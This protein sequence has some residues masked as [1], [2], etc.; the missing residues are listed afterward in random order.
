M[1]FFRRKYVNMPARPATIS[2]RMVILVITCLPALLAGLGMIALWF[3][4]SSKSKTEYYRL[5]AQNVS[6]ILAQDAELLNDEVNKMVGHLAD[7]FSKTYEESVLT[8]IG[9]DTIPSVLF[10]QLFTVTMSNDSFRNVGLLLDNALI[11]TYYDRQSGAPGIYY[12]RTQEDKSVLAVRYLRSKNSSWK[13]HSIVN[14]KKLTSHENTLYQAALKNPGKIVVSQPFRESGFPWF[15][16]F[17]ASSF[18]TSE[19][20]DGVVFG[21]ISLHDFFSMYLSSA[22]AGVDGSFLILNRQGQ[23]L[24]FRGMPDL[25]N[26][27]TIAVPPSCLDI[28]PQEATRE[29]QVLQQAVREGKLK[30]FLDP[31]RM[32]ASND[33]TAEKKETKF[34]FSLFSIESDSLNDDAAEKSK[35]NS[36]IIQHVMNRKPESPAASTEPKRKIDSATVDING[37]NAT[38]F[39]MPVRNTDWLLASVFDDAELSDFLYIEGKHIFVVYVTILLFSCLGFFWFGR[40]HLTRPL[41]KLIRRMDFIRS[42]VFVPAE[43]GGIVREINDLS[44]EVERL[45]RSLRSFAKFIPCEMVRDQIAA[46]QEAIPECASVSATIVFLRAHNFPKEISRSEDFVAR[47]ANYLQSMTALAEQHGGGSLFFN[48]DL[49]AFWKGNTPE[50]AAES[51]CRFMAAAQ[52]RIHA[53]NATWEETTEVPLEISLVAHCGEFLFGNLG[54]EDRLT[55]TILGSGVQLLQEQAEVSLRSGT[56]ATVSREVLHLCQAR[57]LTRPC[58]EAEY[59]GGRLI[60]EEILNFDCESG[61][62]DPLTRLVGRF[63][64]AWHLYERMEYEE[65][66]EMFLAL[67]GEYPQDHLTRYY[68]SLIKDL[69][70]TSPGPNVRSI[71]SR[72]CTPP[73]NM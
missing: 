42:L 40:R 69:I 67:A 10:E 65:A 37:H 61:I 58:S 2:I 41:E 51:A 7:L 73:P 64:S 9:S 26:D 63:T 49:L 30:K 44:G 28:S 46:G 48:A 18:I 25:L 16:I 59:K 13:Q 24:G 52:K 54:T 66:L 56:E 1:L 34:Q 36:E 72:V 4:F 20:R 32:Q 27:P 53:L 71:S 31:V 62:Y 6:G 19:G 70:H 35:P 11:F 14:K 33:P 22:G 8:P 55:Y 39:L 3:N 57:L 68:C 17:Y 12:A 5:L 43:A 29:T 21:S 60:F 45:E 15:N 47:Y 50:Q 23:L 38:I